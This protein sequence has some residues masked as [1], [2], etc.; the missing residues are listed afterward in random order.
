[1]QRIPGDVKSLVTDVEIFILEILK[2]EN[3]TKKAKEK[4]DAL[5]RKL[6]SI[7][8]SYPQE[9]QAKGGSDDS[10]SCEEPVEDSISLASERCDNHDESAAD[11]QRSPPI[12]AQE[13]TPILK[14]GYLEKRRKDHSFFGSEWQKRWCVL[15]NNVFYYYGTEKDKQQKGD[16]VIDGY[17]VQ[18]TTTIRKDAKKDCCF[19]LSAPNK[20]L[21]QFAAASSNEAEEWV[22]Q[23]Q[24]VLKDRGSAMIPEDDEEM[25]DDIDPEIKDDNF[26][27]V[28][29]D[30]D[31]Y[32]ELPEEENDFQ[33]PLSRFDETE[34]KQQQSGGSKTAIKKTEKDKATDYANY[35]QGLWDCSGD[36]SDELSFKRGDVIYILNKEYNSHGWW[37]GQMKDNIGLVPKDYLMEMYDI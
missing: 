19:E 36:Q 20:R 17:T 23:L 11:V 30:D 27:Q 6:N 24:F 28:P 3:L 26:D 21:Y 2:E 8:T 13:L 35:Y 1:M 33:Q 12:P 22:E 5:L 29:I 10:D 7:K 34:N 15:N 37:I 14:A 16:F 9:F 25:Y 32:E 4:K 18:L 31:I